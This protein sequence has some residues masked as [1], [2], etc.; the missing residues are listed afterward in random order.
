MLTSAAADDIVCQDVMRSETARQCA[1]YPA[2][3]NAAREAFEL[4]Q[5]GLKPGTNPQ[6]SLG[7]AI[8]LV[9][10]PSGLSYHVDFKDTMITVVDMWTDYTKHTKA[11]I[12]E[13]H[14]APL[15]KMAKASRKQKKL[16][17]W[18]ILRCMSN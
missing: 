18:V 11:L 4:L 2:I 17:T 12:S 1:T 8:S 13:A 14:I 9:H 5:L 3:V 7:S 6:S 16:R 10:P 15:V